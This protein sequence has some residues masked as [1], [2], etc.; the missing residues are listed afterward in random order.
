M[1]V[2]CVSFNI[3]SA[4][5]MMHLLLHNHNVITDEHVKTIANNLLT[6]PAEVDINAINTFELYAKKRYILQA[7][8]TFTKII[9]S[10]DPHVLCLQEL[11][12]G[13]EHLGITSFLNARGYDIIRGNG[14]AIAYKKA[15]FHLLHSDRTAPDTTAA[16]YIDVKVKGTNKVIR[17]VSDHLAGF[18]TLKQKMNKNT[19]KTSNDPIEKEKAVLGRKR[20]PETGD[21]ALVQN[22]TTV[23]K[24]KTHIPFFS[25]FCNQ[26][27]PDALIYCLDANATARYVSKEHRVHPKRLDQF[28]RHRFVSDETDEKPTICDHSTSVAYKFDYLFAKSAYSVIDHMLPGINSPDMLANPQASMSDHLPVLATVTL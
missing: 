17:I 3:A 25:C 2:R 18:N 15:D 20:A 5:D 8:Q 9:D 12:S 27:A 24:L 7:H 21:I 11:S 4:N 16:L 13:E 6:C 1:Q 28:V 14:L 10:F 23:D 26:D 22:I 19:S